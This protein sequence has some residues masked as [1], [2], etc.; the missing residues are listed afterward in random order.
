[1]FILRK[2]FLV[3]ATATTL[4]G[5]ATVPQSVEPINTQQEINRT[6]GGWEAVPAIRKVSVGN[7]S[8]IMSSVPIPADVKAKKIAIGGPM[9]VFV[10]DLVA[11][12]NMAG[13]P[14]MLDLGDKDFPQK[15]V[16]V[17]DYKGTLGDFTHAVEQAADMAFEW[18]NGVL[19][20]SP[21]LRYAGSERRHRGGLPGHAESRWLGRDYGERK[22]RKPLQCGQSERWV[23]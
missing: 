22:F 11:M 21:G 3:A 13:V 6:T 23:F 4:V 7:S 14:A 8:I 16:F 9:Q 18:R 17:P 20:V 12:I 10:A 2:A 1:M 5:C 15:K 19:V